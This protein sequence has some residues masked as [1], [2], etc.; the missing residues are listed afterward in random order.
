MVLG[1][2]APKQITADQPRRNRPRAAQGDEEGGAEAAIE[3]ARIERE[4]DVQAAE[5]VI[6]HY[7]AGEAVEQMI[8]EGANTRQR[9]RL[10][11]GEHIGEGADTRRHLDWSF[12][13]R[14][15]RGPLVPRCVHLVG[16]ACAGCEREPRA[17][18][19][20]GVG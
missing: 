10:S 6:R 11:R 18:C 20:S 17:D 4:A 7:P 19:H 12:R 3:P 1:R 9:L 5:P 8:V 13:G 2:R 15:P 16:L 14:Q